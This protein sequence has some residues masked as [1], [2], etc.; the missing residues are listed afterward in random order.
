MFESE[1]NSHGGEM[2]FV[3]MRIESKGVGESGIEG[4]GVFG[5]KKG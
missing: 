1:S 2:L 4:K 5:F 3:P